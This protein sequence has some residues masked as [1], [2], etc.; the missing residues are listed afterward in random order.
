[1]THTRILAAL[2]AL[3][4]CAPAGNESS[5]A[6]PA[7]L[8]AERVA[9][10]LSAQIG[11]SQDGTGLSS[12][13]VEEETVVTVFT[14]P[15]PGEGADPGLKQQLTAGIARTFGPQVC[16]EGGIDTLYAA[17]GS[18]LIRAI[19]SDEVLIAEVPAE[20]GEAS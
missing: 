1:M 11:Q 20:C 19:G 5:A 17:G 8:E 13:R 2:A 9:Q 14:L 3:G 6:T 16:A 4:A 15:L 18:L 12:V 7:R 10:A